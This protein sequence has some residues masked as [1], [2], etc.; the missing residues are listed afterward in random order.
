MDLYQF[1]DASDEPILK[2]HQWIQEAKEK[3]VGLAH[4]LNLASVSL[5]GQPSLRIVLLKR[6]S[7]EGL[8]FFTDYGS[9]KGQEIDKNNKVAINF[10][11]A[12]TDKQIRIEGT[13]SKVSEKESDEYFES[14][15]KGS[16]I[17][18]SASN[19]S[20]QIDSYE[21][22]LKVAKKI[23]DEHKDKTISRPLRWGGYILKPNL[24]EFWINKSNRLHERE[25]FT[26]DNGEWKR[27]ILSP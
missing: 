2:T 9:K 15:P 23:E 27:S 18:A 7:D 10:W 14:R 1:I 21:S 8:V 5:N 17:S 6:I 11:W 19:Q 24:I 26:V 4:A 20:S 22:I 3:G 13:C 12:E 25:L 16:Q